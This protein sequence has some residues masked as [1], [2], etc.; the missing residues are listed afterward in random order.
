MVRD[1]S[2]SREV[3][4]GADYPTNETVAAI[5]EPHERVASD[6][7]HAVVDGVALEAWLDTLCSRS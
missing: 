5:R 6:E 7:P 2:L 1:V 3:T 4:P